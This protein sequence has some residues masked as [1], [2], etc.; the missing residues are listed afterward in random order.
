MTVAAD[1]RA[2]WPVATPLELPIGMRGGAPPAR[3]RGRATTSPCG[4]R[5]DLRGAG[6][7]AWAW[8]CDLDVV[9]RRQRIQVDHCVGWVGFGN[10][11]FE[12]RREIVGAH[13]R[14]AMPASVQQAG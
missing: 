12:V 4:Y 11:V 5:P 13:D 9:N 7:D 14:G 1:R 8:L 10:A 6:A 3:R 2:A